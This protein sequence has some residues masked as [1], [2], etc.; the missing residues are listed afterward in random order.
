[1]VVAGVDE[2]NIAAINDESV[3][4]VEELRIAGINRR[5]D[6]NLV[7]KTGP[8]RHPWL[9]AAAENDAITRP[10]KGADDRH[11]LAIVL[12]EN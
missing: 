6:P 1:M 3:E 11:H 4:G 8:L 9:L 2:T 5:V 12:T 7:N 10:A